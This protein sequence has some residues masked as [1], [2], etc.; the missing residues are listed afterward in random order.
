MIVEKY[1]RHIKGEDH[2]DSTLA[3]ETLAQ[4]KVYVDNSDITAPIDCTKDEYDILTDIN[5]FTK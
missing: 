1:N 2:L 4:D 5:I 3:L